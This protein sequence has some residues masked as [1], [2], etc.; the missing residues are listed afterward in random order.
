MSTRGS[1]GSGH[2][3]AS[4][5]DAY[6]TVDLAATMSST[7]LLVIGDSQPYQP[8]QSLHKVTSSSDLDDVDADWVII[9]AGDR[10]QTEA[11]AK[12]LRQHSK[13][14]AVPVF[15]TCESAL[16]SAITDG[17]TPPNVGEWIANY[18]EHLNQLQLVPNSLKNK[19]IIYLY[20]HRSRRLCPVRCEVDEGVYRYP[21]IDIWGDGSLSDA[22]LLALKRGNYL[23]DEKLVDRFRFCPQCSG[24][25]LNFVETCPSCNTIDIEMMRGIHCF[26]CGYVDQQSK[27]STDYRLV[28]PNCDTQLNNIGTDY[29]RPL[30]NFVCKQCDAM[31]V[32]GEVKAKCFD[33]DTVSDLN[34]LSQQM[35]YI[36]GLA[37]QGEDLAEVGM[38]SLSL[39]GL[40]EGLVSEGHFNWLIEWS[41]GLSN[42]YG[43]DFAVITLSFKNMGEL[44]KSQSS[45]EMLE[46]LDV[47]IS[48]L[49]S[50]LRT[51]DVTCQF[52]ADAI[53][54]LLPYQTS[55]VLEIMRKKIDAILDESSKSPLDIVMT[56]SSL[57]DEGIAE[58]SARWLERKVE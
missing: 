12:I 56:I 46:H 55:D 38:T 40:L 45:A 49:N 21:L 20:L 53:A 10:A 8:H 7:K 27:F 33:C 29:D 16:L 34:A 41:N 22:I 48:K 2:S 5:G 13:F 43:H 6:S 3:H 39:E 14:Y 52:K 31:F 58:N 54:I 19:I 11:Y 42:R 18:R 25:Q 15:T 17:I 47:F 24:A 28:C 51:T 35:I 26:G 32:D 37:K 57:P 44:L 4:D 1:E 36:H 30:E 9:N 50:M 23:T